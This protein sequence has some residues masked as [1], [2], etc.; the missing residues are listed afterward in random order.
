MTANKKAPARKAAAKKR[1]TKAD[2]EKDVARLTALIADKDK[3]IK[4]LKN[5]E[6]Y[7][8][9]VVEKSKEIEKKLK[10]AQANYEH[11]VR[12]YEKNVQ[13]LQERYEEATRPKPFMA[14]LKAV[15]TG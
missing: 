15:V 4:R 8:D 7:L 13:A 9:R 11:D 6:G 12:Y 1:V 5:S 14:R 2:L 3:E 10:N